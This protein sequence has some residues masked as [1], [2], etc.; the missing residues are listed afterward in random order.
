MNAGENDSD[1]AVFF[2]AFTQIGPRPDKHPAARWKLS[3]LLA[4]MDHCS[5]SRAMV[6]STLSVNYDAMHS[7]LALSEQLRSH[8]RLLAIWNVIPDTTGEMPPLERLGE[9]MRSHNVRAVTIYPKT[10]AWDV[11][12]EPGCR[13]LAWMADNRILTILDRWEFGHYRELDELLSRNP[14]L[15]VLLRGAYWNEQRYVVPL[16]GRHAN[17]NISF[18]HFQVHYGPEYLCQLGYEDQLLF[19][20]DGPSMSAGAHRCYVDYA[21]VSP[22]IRAKIANG[23]LLRLL[24]STKLFGDDLPMPPQR[25]NADEDELMAAART[26]SPLPATLIDMHMHILHEGLNGAGGHNVMHQGG[27]EGVFALL[28]R[29]GCNGG[30]L[31][32]WVGTVS[33]DAVAGNECVAAALDAA[34]KGYWGLAT[35]DPTHYGPAEMSEQ[36]EQVYSDQ[37]FIGMKPY[38]RFGVAYDDPAYDPW[39]RFGND[40]HFYGLL[41]CAGRGVGQVE[42]LARKYPNIR[43]LIAHAGGDWHGADAAIQVA[44]EFPNVFLEITYTPVHAGMIEY[45]L[46]GAGADRVVYGSDLPMRDPRQQLGWVV[47]SRLP[48]EDKR[49][50]IGLNAMGILAPCFEQ[51]PEN[52]RPDS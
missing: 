31:M 44:R 6:S 13:L 26:G 7:N 2:D 3:E 28:G 34:P 49:K 5:I 8:G 22:A 52:S 18:D 19:A 33:A 29:L 37:R 23:N 50:V 42:T 16:L 35:F 51:L 1:G 40:H 36:I 17:L 14:D 15:P 9:L 24:N 25:S 38:H 46:D 10:N 30:G 43:W 41:D 39:W 48:A 47:Y 45:L 27:P 11:A 4:E 12:S 20:T 21:D 32:S